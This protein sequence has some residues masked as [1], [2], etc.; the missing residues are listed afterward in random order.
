[1]YFE[2]RTDKLKSMTA[3]SIVL[4]P[5]MSP[6]PPH[7][8]EEEEFMLVAEGTGEIVCGDET[9]HVAPGAMMYC[10]GDKLHGITNTGATPMLFY[11]YKWL[12]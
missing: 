3:G 10:A 7:F 8:H 9:K 12:A 1:M 2:G 11:F 6:H 5:G 4:A